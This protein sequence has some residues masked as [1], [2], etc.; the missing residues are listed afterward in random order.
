MPNLSVLDLKNNNL[1]NL[2]PSVSGLKKLKTLDVSNNDLIDLP[3]ELGFL[4]SLVLA[5]LKRSQS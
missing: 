3:N 2:D 1:L 5:S 4:Q